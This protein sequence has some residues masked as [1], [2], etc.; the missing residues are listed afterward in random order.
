MKISVVVI[1]LTTAVDFHQT[2][3]KLAS[4]NCKLVAN[5]QVFQLELKGDYKDEGDVS[6]IIELNNFCMILLLDSNSEHVTH[7]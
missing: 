3:L 7:E 5:I 1:L 2:Y 4:E 6:I